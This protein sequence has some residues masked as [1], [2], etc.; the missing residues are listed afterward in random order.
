MNA[1]L[2]TEFRKRL[3][4]QRDR[5]VAEWKNHGG[6]TGPGDEWDLRD[7]EQRADLATTETVE[8]RIAEDDRNLLRKVDFALKRLDEGTYQTCERCGAEIPIDRLL[9]KPSVS[10]CLACQELKDAAREP[11]T[12]R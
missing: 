8:R 4:E 3:V 9:A 6:S 10:L 11:A 1:T 12:R 7:L 5:I 2:T